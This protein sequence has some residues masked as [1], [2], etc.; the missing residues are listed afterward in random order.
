MSAQDVLYHDKAI[1]IASTQMIVD[2][3]TH[4]VSP[5]QAHIQTIVNAVSEAMA[6]REV[7]G[8]HG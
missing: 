2:K 7:C 3:T 4:L 6:R 5:K 8:C 1:H